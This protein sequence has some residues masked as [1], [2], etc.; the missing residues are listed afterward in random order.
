MARP[1]TARPRPRGARR[2]NRIKG[3]QAI[4]RAPAGTFAGGAPRPGGV[5][6]SPVLSRPPATGRP[7]YGRP[8]P[9]PGPSMGPPLPGPGGPQLS[10]PFIPGATLAP[11]VPAHQSEVGS[12]PGTPNLAAMVM[13]SFQP[14]VLQSTPLVSSGGGGIPQPNPSYNFGGPQLPRGTRGVAPQGSY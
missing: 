10:H 11:V 1:V 9:G 7:S 14:S 8:D 2:P 3:L 6:Q 12:P 4:D 13:R 5:T